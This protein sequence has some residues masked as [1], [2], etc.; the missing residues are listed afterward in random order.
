MELRED[1]AAFPP[2]TPA[3]LPPSPAPA[4]L[5]PRNRLISTAPDWNNEAFLS[6]WERADGR[7]SA[8]SYANDQ[9]LGY[10]DVGGYGKY[11]E[12]WVDCAADAHHRRQRAADDQGR[13]HGLPDQAPSCSTP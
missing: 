4:C 1:Q 12:W 6:S 3:Y 9:R 10:V 5:R 2:V 7:A 8:R 13:H 11:G